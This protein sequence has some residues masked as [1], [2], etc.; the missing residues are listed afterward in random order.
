MGPT[1]RFFKLIIFVTLQLWHPTQPLIYFYVNGRPKLF[2]EV[3][4]NT[5]KYYSFSDSRITGLIRILVLVECKCLSSFTVF[6]LIIRLELSIFLKLTNL[7]VRS[8]CWFSWYRQETSKINHL[9]FY[10]QRI[11]KW[12]LYWISSWKR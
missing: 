5:Y 11:L 9:C 1:L 2:L 8:T 4:L 6:T 12:M 3:E 7:K 10:V